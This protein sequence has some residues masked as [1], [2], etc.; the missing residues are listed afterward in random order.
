MTVCQTFF[1]LKFSKF[2][3]NFKTLKVFGK[4][5]FIVWLNLRGYFDFDPLPTKRCQIT[6]LRRKF[7][8]PTD[9]NKQLFKFS[10]QERDLSL[11]VG[12]GIKVNI[13]SEIKPPFVFTK[14]AIGRSG[15][16]KMRRMS[17]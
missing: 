4:F 2:N 11:F 14:G 12:N 13:P 15:R 10:A 3:Q 1:K 8:F 5:L 17:C 16:P 9:N 7:E 6:L